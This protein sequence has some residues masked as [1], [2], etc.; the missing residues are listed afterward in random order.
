MKK[1]T[2][3]LLEI[4]FAEIPENILTKNEKIQ[5]LQSLATIDI[6]ILKPRSTSDEDK[7]NEKVKFEEFCITIKLFENR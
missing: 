2:L 5:M 7:L 4:S 3:E 1:T 6:S